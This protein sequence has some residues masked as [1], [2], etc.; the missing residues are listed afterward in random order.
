[1]NNRQRFDVLPGLLYKSK[2]NEGTLYPVVEMIALVKNGKCFWRVVVQV[3]S[4]WN[5]NRVFHFPLAFYPGCIV[6]A[7]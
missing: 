6:E 1:M 5:S 3:P 2:G 4:E 7:K